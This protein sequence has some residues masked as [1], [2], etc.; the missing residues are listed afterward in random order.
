MTV[1][2]VKATTEVVEEKSYIETE[3]VDQEEIKSIYDE[4]QS[5]LKSKNPLDFYF[6][7]KKIKDKIAK[8]IKSIVDEVVSFFDMKNNSKIYEMYYQT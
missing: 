6:K 3:F 5:V 8:I 2:T 1:K 4:I 7:I